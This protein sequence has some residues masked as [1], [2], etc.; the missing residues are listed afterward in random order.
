MFINT[1]YL[2]KILIIDKFTIRMDRSAGTPEV[3]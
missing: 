2:Q 1:Q 3:A